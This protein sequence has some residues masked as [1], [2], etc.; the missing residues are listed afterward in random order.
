MLGWTLL[1]IHNHS[2]LNQFFANVRAALAD[3]TFDEKAKQFA[4]RYEPDF[5]EGAAERPRA[6]GYQYKSVG[7]DPK[8]NKP[9]WSKMEAE[10]A[11]RAKE[12]EGEGEGEKG[13][14]AAG[15]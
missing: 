13:V 3:G 10:K 5:P 11:E 4:L 2:I 1:S 8:R 7:G 9:A 12:E 15:A 6:R 14:A